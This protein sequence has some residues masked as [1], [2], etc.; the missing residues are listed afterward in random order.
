[1][2]WFTLALFAV[3]FLLTAL[4][5]PAPDVEEARPEGLDPNNFPRESERLPIHEES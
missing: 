2:V 4:L 5:S 3:S 1:M